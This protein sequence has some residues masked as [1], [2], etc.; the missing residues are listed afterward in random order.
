M[1]AVRRAHSCALGSWS[2]GLPSCLRPSPFVVGCYGDCT[3]G[4]FMRAGV[5]DSWSAN[6]RTAASFRSA[7]RTRGLPTVPIV[8][9]SPTMLFSLEHLS[10]PPRPPKL[11]TVFRQPYRADSAK[12]IPTPTP[13]PRAFG[14][15]VSNDRARPCA[16]IATPHG[17]VLY[18]CRL[19]ALTPAQSLRALSID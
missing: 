6:P 18:R 5:L 15:P 12:A 17:F 19:N 13:F 7:G 1:T 2:P 14:A 8:T 16:L 3:R 4:A 10:A 11:A 9:V